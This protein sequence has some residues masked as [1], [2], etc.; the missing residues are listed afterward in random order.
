M[1]NF[2]KKLQKQFWNTSIKMKIDDVIGMTHTFTKVQSNLSMTN[3]V[4]IW[5]E[6]A[7]NSLIATFHFVFKKQR[8]LGEKNFGLG[9]LNT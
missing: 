8:F 3:F 4:M 5:K 7:E 1:I 2:K 9:I 6:I